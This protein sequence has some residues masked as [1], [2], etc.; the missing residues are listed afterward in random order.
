MTGARLRTLMLNENLGGHA[1]AHLALERALAGHPEVSARFVEVPPPGLLRRVA[2]VPVAGLARLD[3]DLQPLRY[4]LAQSAHVRRRLPGWLADADVVH[5]YTHNA[6]LLSARLLAERPSVVSLDATNAQNAFNIPYR[7]ATRFTAASARPAQRLERRVYD[8]ATAVVT[9]SAWAAA[10]VVGYGVDPAKVHVVPFGIDVHDVPEVSPPPRPQITFVGNSMTRK[11][12]WRLLEL[13]RRHFADRADLTLVTREA[14]RP[15]PGVRVLN[16]IRP[17]DPRL[18]T[19]LAQTTVFAF[20]TDMDAFGYAA[21]EAMAMGVPVVASS[22]AALPE[23][24]DDG[25]TGLLV[26]VGDDGALRGAI[27][28][29]L[30][31]QDRA[32][33][34]G[35]A[36]RA[37]VLERFDARVTT[38]A[39]VTLLQRA[40]S[41]RPPSAHPAAGRR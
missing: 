6:A 5:V 10:S 20:P 33:R 30:D 41:S 24:V 1:T 39:L 40:A 9:H 18:R 7:R 11:G 35:Q 15:E 27:A 23:I 8:A 13:H 19:V 37:R 17:G 36:G 22:M 14:V 26:P 29:L 34:L 38:A 31:D 25:T 28:A 21:V 3:L 4:Q 12:G 32:R 2:A 16:D